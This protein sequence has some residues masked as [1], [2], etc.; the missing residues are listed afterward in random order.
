MDQPVTWQQG[1]VPL[2][3]DQQ[4]VPREVY[5]DILF[6][7]PFCQYRYHWFAEDFILYHGVPDNI[8]F[9]EGT[10]FNRCKMIFEVHVIYQSYYLPRD[11]EAYYW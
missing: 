9:D 11:P 3:E 8:I 4:F 6:M 2:M 1:G 7:P 5:T 10:H